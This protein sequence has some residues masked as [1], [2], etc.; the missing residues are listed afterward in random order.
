M[1]NEVAHYCQPANTVAVGTLGFVDTRQAAKVD[2][3]VVEHAGGLSLLIRGEGLRRALHL[4]W[5]EARR[6]TDDLLASIA[7]A[8][9][10]VQMDVQADGIAQPV[11]ASD[12]SSPN[13]QA[14]P[15]LGG[16]ESHEQ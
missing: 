3:S 2:V 13:A 7:A 16:S 11:L 8:P 1:A 15:G 9:I 14:L 5:P 4:G 10:D 6:L 12:G